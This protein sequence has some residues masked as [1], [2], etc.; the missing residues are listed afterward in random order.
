MQTSYL[1]PRFDPASLEWVGEDLVAQTHLAPGSWLD[2]RCMQA[3]SCQSY[4]SFLNLP[5]TL[6]LFQT[7]L[8]LVFLLHKQ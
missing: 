4:S 5:A 1:S 2:F 3:P 8:T 6:N 7:S